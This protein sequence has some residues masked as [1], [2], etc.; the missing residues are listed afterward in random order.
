MQRSRR[1]R[2][3]PDSPRP[4]GGP[5][6]SRAGF[7]QAGATVAVVICL[8]AALDRRGVG[9]ARHP[10]DCG[11]CDRHAPHPRAAAQPP[12]AVA[13]AP[14]RDSRPCGGTDRR[15]PAHDVRA[16]R[17]RCAPRLRHRGDGQ[18]GCAADADQRRSVLGV[19]D[20]RDPGPRGQRRTAVDGLVPR[21]R[22]RRALGHRLVGN[23]TVSGPCLPR[24]PCSPAAEKQLL[25][26]F[27]AAQAAPASG[28]SAPT[29][30]SA[31]HRH[32]GRQWQRDSARRRHN[33]AWR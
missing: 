31:P 8:I 19:R 11:A 14:H 13:D 15:R 27:S 5:L 21:A 6:R 7:P 12:A 26:R 23:R 9:L 32:P 1:G 3:L 4:S 18:A 17:I 2:C 33:V 20:N 16:A 24:R 25:A 22:K 30:S 10:H 28:A 29:E